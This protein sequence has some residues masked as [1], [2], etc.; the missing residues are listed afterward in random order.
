MKR[1]TMGVVF[2]FLVTTLISGCGGSSDSTPA[3]TSG[4]AVDPYITNAQFQE[5]L[6]DGTRGQLSTLSDDLGRF[7]FAEPL[8]EGS[9]VIMVAKGVHNGV[10][11]EGSLKSH[12]DFID[13]ELIVSP[14]TTVLVN[15]MESDPTLTEEE[16][17]IALLEMLVA[18]GHD[19][20][21]LDTAALTSDPMPGVG[22]GGSLEALRGAMAVNGWLQAM[23]NVGE[24]G[25][26]IVNSSNYLSH[27]QD[28]Q[29]LLT[30]M[31]TAMEA[32]LGE[33]NFGTY[34]TTLGQGLPEGYPLDIDDMIRA[35]VTTCNGLAVEATVVNG[36]FEVPQVKDGS[37]EEAFIRHY[38]GR[39]MCEPGFSQWYG[40]LRELNPSLPEITCGDGFTMND[41][42][43][44]MDGRN[45]MGDWN[46]DGT[47]G[48]GDS[49]GTMP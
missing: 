13:G 7:S 8:S 17:K 40:E 16:A 47:W 42:H 33:G 46:Q 21:L 44:D 31:S 11:Y 29:Q 34:Q 27:L 15:L 36:I 20:L 39:N 22:D 3:G 41:I 28:R 1:W 49:W 10:L 30:D 4:I 19:P 38:T 43:N 2:L 9:R 45:M 24:N 37:F 35:A 32:Y 12:T 26:D 6:E 14:F 48:M 25:F 18:A 5:I 23:T